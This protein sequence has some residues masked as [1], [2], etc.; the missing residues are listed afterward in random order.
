MDVSFWAGMDFLQI[1]TRSKYSEPGTSTVLF[2]SAA[3]LSH[4]KGKLVYA[5]AKTAVNAAVRSAAKEICGK[6]HRV[7][8]ILP[9]WTDTPMTEK[10]SMTNDMNAVLSRLPLGIGTPE[11]ISQAV[12]FLLSDDSCC[13]TGSNFVVDGGFS[14]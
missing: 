14:A 12:M 11:N 9:G 10:L 5:S 8:S 2:S 1:V 7:N 6:K 3:A 13:I 4:D